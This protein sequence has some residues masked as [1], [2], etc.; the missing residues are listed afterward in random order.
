MFLDEIIG[1]PTT[2]KRK[3]KSPGERDKNAEPTMLDRF[4][5]KSNVVPKGTTEE[6]VEERKGGADVFMNEDGTM[7]IAE[8]S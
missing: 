2:E 4:V 8:D 6:E 1:C 5:T 7:G 3:P